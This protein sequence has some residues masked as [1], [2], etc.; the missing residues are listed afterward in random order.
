M[1][2]VVKN[3]TEVSDIDEA[4]GIIKGYANVYNVKDSDGDI[5]LYG[6][7]AKTVTERGR[8][9]KIFKNHHPELVGVPT[10]FDLSDTYGLGMTAKMLMDTEGGRNAF[11]EVKFLSQNGFESGM[12]IGG[13]ITKR[14]E[15]NKSEVAE[16]RLKEISVLTTN[17]PA[18]SLSLVTAIKSIKALTEPTQ[19][20]FWKV[21]EKAYDERGFSDS[22]KK[23]L[24]Q[25]LTLKDHEPDDTS[26]TTQAEEP[27]QI[28]KSI[29]ELY[30]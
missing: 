17:D 29:Y 30:T 14:N 28:I 9:I 19:A 2:E 1:E 7:F 23:S 16:Y 27:S 11:H 26:R 6:S 10:E 18:N 20:E 12:S 15:K 24:E 4:T 3:I 13:W 8:K 25:F 22:I 5:S 21:I